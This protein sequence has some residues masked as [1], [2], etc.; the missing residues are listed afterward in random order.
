MSIYDDKSVPKVDCTPSNEHNP[1]S[2]DGHINLLAPTL[3][4]VHLSHG[5]RL[6]GSSVST[7]LNLKIIPPRRIAFCGGGMRCIAHI[8]ALKALHKEGLLSCVKEMYGV[9]AGALFSFIYILGYSLTE[10]E[11]LA[12]EFDFRLLK[13]IDPDS[14]FLFPFT[15]GL[16]NGDGLDKLITILLKRKGFSPDL[17]FKELDS[18]KPIRFRCY[19]TD[20]QTCSLKDFSVEST[21]LTPVRIALRAT[22]SLPV[23]YTP[24]KDPD[25]GH[26]LMDGGLLH[27]LPLTFLSDYE[28]QFT[29]AVLFESDTYMKENEKDSF[30]LFDIF[31]SMYDSIVYMRNKLIIEQHDN[32]IM[33]LKLGSFHGLDFDK[34]RDDKKKLIDLAENQSMAWLK[35]RSIKPIR[36]FSVS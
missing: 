12:L 15:F 1:S 29:L 5:N 36:R 33:V 18:S 35:K 23:L 34:G 19:A 11:K 3:E 20:L 17:T 30:E 24:V 4:P 7:D 28:K 13:N 26:L 21:P 16:D 2:S 25:N 9:S 22:M 32:K 10:I 8:G 14:A 31:K 6:V 27:N